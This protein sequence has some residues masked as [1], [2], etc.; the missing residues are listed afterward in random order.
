LIK[1]GTSYKDAQPHKRHFF[2]VQL[3]SFP[4]NRI[5]DSLNL[6]ILTGIFV[7]IT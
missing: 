3:V 7:C 6:E 1:Y 5:Y 2:C 4:F